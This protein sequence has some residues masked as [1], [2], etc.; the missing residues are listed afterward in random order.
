[1][2]VDGFELAYDRAGSGPA[3]VLLHGWPGDRTDYRDLVPLLSGC[4]VIVPDLRGFGHSDKHVANP[5][6]QYGSPAQARSVADLITSLGISRA[7]VV[8]YDIGSRIAQALAR[9][10]PDLVSALV[11]SPPVPGVGARVFGPGPLREFW[12]Q[13]FHR[14]P[15]SEQL[16]D[17]HPDAV[18]AYLRHFWEHWSGPE[19]TLSESHLDHLVSV[20]GPPGA[21]TASVQWYRAGAGTTTAAASET[22]P[23]PEDRLATPAVVLWPEFDPLFPREWS[24]RIDAFFSRARLRFVDGAG[25][26]APLEYPAVL[27]EEVR[28]FLADGSA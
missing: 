6:E 11:I 15:L 26:Y 18:R 28:R 16:I 25:H 12:Y 27:A 13:A 9:S 14:L 8:G 24:D 23:A 2:A 10:R 4:E 5:A 20:Y 17:G 22:I 19:F 3:V 21:F 7:V 1:M